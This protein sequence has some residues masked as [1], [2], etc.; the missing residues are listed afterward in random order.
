MLFPNNAV[1]ITLNNPRTGHREQWVVDRHEH[2]IANAFARFARAQGILP[3]EVEI[4]TYGPVS[5]G[6]ADD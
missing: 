3:S 1:V 4:L 5:M 2:D 6:W